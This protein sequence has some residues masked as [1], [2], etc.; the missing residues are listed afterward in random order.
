DGQEALRTIR[1]YESRI[2]VREADGVRVIMTTALE[3][4]KN[5]VE[6][7]YRGAATSYLVKPIER[8]TLLAELEKIGLELGAPGG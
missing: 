7:Y 4:P 1:E 3:D 5:V 8:E 2:G 6:A